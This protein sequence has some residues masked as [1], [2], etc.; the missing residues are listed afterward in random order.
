[1]VLGFVL[2]TLGGLLFTWFYALAFAALDTVTW[3]VG[4][5]MGLGHGFFLAAV[6]L[7][8]LPFVHPRMRTHYDGPASRPQ[9]EPPGP[10][11]LNYGRRT[12]IITI[13]AQSLFGVILGAALGPQL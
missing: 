1:V 4:G 11:G 8:L 5:L 9:L 3:W 13:V 2:Y 7:P 6:F 12:P 10:F